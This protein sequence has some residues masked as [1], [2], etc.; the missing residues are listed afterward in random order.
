M[1][2]LFALQYYEMSYGLNIEMHKQVG[3][4]E[5][6]FCLGGWVH[7]TCSETMNCVPLMR[8]I[9][10]FWVTINPEHNCH[11]FICQHESLSS[12]EMLSIVSIN[13]SFEGAMIASQSWCLFLAPTPSRILKK[14]SI[15]LR[16]GGGGGPFPFDSSVTVC[17]IFCGVA[18]NICCM[19]YLTVGSMIPL[20]LSFFLRYGRQ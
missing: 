3:A 17:H 5:G 2:F 1:S 15:G 13:I 9:Y 4:L 12:I 20:F 6:F 7:Q 10:F 14:S 19:S 16:L 11:Q 8:R 18:L